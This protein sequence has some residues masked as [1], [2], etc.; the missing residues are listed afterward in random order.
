[1]DWIFIGFLVASILHMG[2]EYLYPGG[3]MDFMKRLNPRI[4]PQITTPA[5][6][7]INGL[8]LLLC[9]IAVIVGKSQPQFSLSVAALLIIN[10]F[11]HMG[12]CIRVKG[13]APGVVTGVFLYLP[14]SLYAYYLF[15]SAGRLSGRGVLI[16]A[17]L[18]LLYQMV[19]LM[20]FGIATARR[21]ASALHNP[22]D[23]KQ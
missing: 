17:A 4:A 8:Q 19:P 13:Y 22:A 12:G 6:V 23:Q 1:M 15:I 7:I 21:K 5:A 2:E 20:Y 9:L 14:L 16:T 3:F 10:G 11:I 18:G